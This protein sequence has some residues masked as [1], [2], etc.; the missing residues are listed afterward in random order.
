MAGD[1]VTAVL[2]LA[3]DGSVL[4]VALDGS[5]LAVGLV[6]DALVLDAL[7]LEPLGDL[8]GLVLE[9]LGDLPPFTLERFTFLDACL[10]GSPG[11][12]LF[13]G[14]SAEVAVVAALVAAL[15]SDALRFRVDALGSPLGLVGLLVVF[16]GLVSLTVAL[17]QEGALFF[18]GGELDP[19]ASGS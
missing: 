5:V 9:P 7:V 19:R 12:A 3:L 16:F 18:L 10:G 2:G 14:T 8:A 13:V 15:V 4:D 6:L 17:L 1:A 11:A